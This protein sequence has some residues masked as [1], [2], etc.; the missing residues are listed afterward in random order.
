MAISTMIAQ[1]LFRNI[2]N[3]REHEK[4]SLIYLKVITV[5]RVKEAFSRK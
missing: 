4:T 3:K 5:K 1:A 2:G